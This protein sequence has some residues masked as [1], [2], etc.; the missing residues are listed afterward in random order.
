MNVW[1]SR[2][3]CRIHPT[4]FISHTPP[5]QQSCFLL[6]RH[7]RRLLPLDVGPDVPPTRDK[8]AFV[9]LFHHKAL[10]SLK[11]V[12]HSR[13][14]VS[15]GCNCFCFADPAQSMTVARTTLRRGL[16]H[17]S[18]DTIDRSCLQVVSGSCRLNVR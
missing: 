4:G 7:F 8:N 14:F 2:M 6:M 10:S 11:P 18:L 17:S 9:Y 16:H 13:L 1:S 15:L 5:L 3:N 12:T